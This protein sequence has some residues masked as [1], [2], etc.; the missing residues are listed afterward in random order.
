VTVDLKEL[1]DSFV[2]MKNAT[3]NCLPLLK[4]LR[5]LGLLP[6]V[7]VNDSRNYFTHSLYLRMFNCV[8][9]LS[10][11]LV[12][13]K[14]CIDQVIYSMS[15]S[16]IASNVKANILGILIV[17]LNLPLI[18]STL[19][20]SWKSCSLCLKVLQILS[21]SGTCKIITRSHYLKLGTL[22]AVILT[23]SCTFIFQIRLTAIV[24]WKMIEMVASFN[25]ILQFVSVIW[26]FTI[27]LLIIIIAL[28][29]S[30]HFRLINRE[31]SSLKKCNANFYEPSFIYS[32]RLSYERIA[33]VQQIVSKQFSF[34]ITVLLLRTCLNLLMPIVFIVSTISNKISVHNYMYLY[35]LEEIMFMVLLCWACNKVKVE[36]RVCIF[37]K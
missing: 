17:S 19:C 32:L 12:S 31:L 25:E 4:A 21:K 27:T 14:R 34:F 30:E 35:L 5:C 20:F 23:I 3:F 15:V 24:R 26:I 9:H 16:L 10:V 29:L 13:I 36:V 22:F 11:L 8:L 28:H 33:R 1:L 6:F 2:S 7:I 37:I 18:F